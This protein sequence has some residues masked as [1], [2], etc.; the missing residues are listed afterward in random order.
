MATHFMVDFF[1]VIA[2]VK[3]SNLRSSLVAFEAMSK[4]TLGCVKNRRCES[5]GIKS[6]LAY[7]TAR[8]TLSH[9][10]L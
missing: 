5:S 1:T 3:L 4:H 10:S 6:P 9:A 2:R 8:M 7:F